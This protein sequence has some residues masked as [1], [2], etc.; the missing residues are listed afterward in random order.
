MGGI[1]NSVKTRSRGYS[2]D[3]LWYPPIGQGV[4]IIVLFQ[5]IR[6]HPHGGVNFGLPTRNLIIRL[7]AP[8]IHYSLHCTP[9][10]FIKKQF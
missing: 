6:M 1:A 9:L 2:F 3:T 4:H 5:Y 7:L 8:R 10:D